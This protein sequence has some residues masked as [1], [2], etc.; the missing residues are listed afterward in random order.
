MQALKGLFWILRGRTAVKRILSRCIPCKKLRGKP[1]NQVMADLP[2]DRVKPGQPAFTDVGLDY[3]GPFLVK[4]AR[5][6]AKRYG[7]LFTCLATR[8]VHL[9]IAHILDTDSFIN[10]LQRFIARRGEPKTV[11]SDNGRNLVGANHELKKALLDL[12]QTKVYKALSEKNIQWIFNPPAASHMGGVWERVICTV[13]AVLQGLMTQQVLDDEGLLTLM[14]ITESII[15]SR[16]LTK[17]SDDPND[18]TPLTPNHLLL[19]RS[20]KDEPPSAFMPQHSFRRRWRQV[21]YLADLFWIR[22]TKE[23]LPTL[24]CRSKWTDVSANLHVGDLVLLREDGTTRYQWP[25]G[26]ITETY[27]GQDGIVR[28]VQLRT[29]D[30]LYTRPISKICLLECSHNQ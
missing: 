6:R 2:E 27:Q 20:G 30:G 11:R 17:L 23:Y 29:K 14:C 24:Q 10:T 9:E 22:W 26:L 12:N 21:Q 16:P 7:C 25:L 3:F 18:L 1:L 13:R 4:R 28:S 15:N 5:Q 19:L 8:A